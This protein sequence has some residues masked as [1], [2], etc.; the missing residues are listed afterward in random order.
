MRTNAQPID[1]AAPDR[2]A[3]RVEG[4]TRSDDGG[5]MGVIA[6]WAGTAD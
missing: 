4:G 6:D 1:A 2:P 5:W 3:L